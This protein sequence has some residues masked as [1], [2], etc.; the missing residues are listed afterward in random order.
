MSIKYGRK[1][2]H[3]VD[4]YQLVIECSLAYWSLNYFV[5]RLSLSFLFRYYY[6]MK[7][8]M[9]SCFAV[10]IFF[11]EGNGYHFS[12]Y[13]FSWNLVN[14]SL[15]TFFEIRSPDK[16][17]KYSFKCLFE[18]NCSLYTDNIEVN[19]NINWIIRFDVKNYLW[20]AQNSPTIQRYKVL[21]WLIPILMI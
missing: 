21:T 3:C 6:L 19:F 16:C 20:A 8:F 10:I 7:S 2:S 17:L 4:N 1:V 11:K 13:Y 9:I 14:A 18:V 15:R 5:D 12:V